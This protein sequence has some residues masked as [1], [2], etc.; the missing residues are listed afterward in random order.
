MTDPL[1][2]Q[3]KPEIQVCETSRIVTF[4]SHFYNCCG[5]QTKHTC[6]QYSTM[7]VI[8]YQDKDTGKKLLNFAK[9]L[10]CEPIQG[11]SALAS[12]NPDPP[13]GSWWLRGQKEAQLGGLKTKTFTLPSSFSCKTTLQGGCEDDGIYAHKSASPIHVKCF[14]NSVCGQSLCHV[15]LFVTPWTVSHQ[16]PV[17]G[18][19]QARILEWVAMSSSRG[20]SQPRD[21]T[22]VSCIDRQILYH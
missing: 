7:T 10:T 15:Q 20:S 8:Y 21:Q 14:I 16:A 4:G 17:R 6:G 9:P 2:F 19:L 22:C 18:I 3:E 11:F 1:I 13:Q 5:N 12:K